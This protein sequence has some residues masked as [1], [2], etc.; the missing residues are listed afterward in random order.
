MFDSDLY[1]YEV[2]SKL[3]RNSDEKFIE[4]LQLYCL[5]CDTIGGKSIAK[6]IVCCNVV[7]FEYKLYTYIHWG[8]GEDSVKYKSE[9]LPPKTLTLEECKSVLPTIL[10]RVKNYKYTISFEKKYRFADI[11]VEVVDGEL[12]ILDSQ[13]VVFTFKSFWE[14]S[15][16]QREFR[17]NTFKVNGK[18]LTFVLCETDSNP[19]IMFLA[20]NQVPSTTWINLKCESDDDNQGVFLKNATPNFIKTRHLEMNYRLPIRSCQMS[21]KDKNHKITI[22]DNQVI[23]TTISM[24]FDIEAYMPKNIDRLDLG[25]DNRIFQISCVVEDQHSNVHNYLL[26]LGKPLEILDNIIVFE[27]D[28]EV[29]LLEKFANL[30]CF[31]KPT[32]IM[33]WNIYN[34]DLTFM[35]CRLKNLNMWDSFASEISFYPNVSAHDVRVADTANKKFSKKAIDNTQHS[36]NNYTEDGKNIILPGCVFMDVMTYLKKEFA[37]LESYKLDNVAKKYFGEQKDDVSLSDILNAY[38]YNI[39]DKSNTLAARVLLGK[40]GNYCVKDS[41]LVLKIYNFK[42]YYPQINI[43]AKVFHI[44]LSTLIC[45]NQN[46]RIYASIFS[47]SKSNVAI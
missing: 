34:F 32:I 2:Q 31:I 39:I 14:K 25:D 3:F 27:C 4:C 37:K 8:S 36:N 47:L 28:S 10:H 23:P 19:E 16:F 24:S 20:Y 44:P 42:K 43:F 21:M 45:R 1:L 33:G 22:L 29:D 26:T 13:Y 38:R 5:R 12:K 11:E 40:V 17:D 7:D 46:I 6:E 15:K 18:D 35:I 30:V 9:V 41:D